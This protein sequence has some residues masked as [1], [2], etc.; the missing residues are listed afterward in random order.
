MA[1]GNGTPKAETPTREYRG[2]VE[3]ATEARNVLGRKWRAYAEEQFL[4][5]VKQENPNATVV[6]SV[7]LN[8]HRHHI[9]HNVIYDFSVN[10]VDA[11]ATTPATTPRE[12]E[13]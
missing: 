5:R 7:T 1:R 11:S 3:L 10:L 12:G 2:T 8:G 4:A 6:G 9:G 13:V